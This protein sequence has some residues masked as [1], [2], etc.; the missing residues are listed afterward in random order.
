MAPSKDN[1]VVDTSFTESTVNNSSATNISSS[2]TIN[3]KI[4][5]NTGAN[6]SKWKYFY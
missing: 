2:E 6:I 5:N 4:T 3:V 1:I